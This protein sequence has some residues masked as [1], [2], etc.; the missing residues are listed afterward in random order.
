MIEIMI[1]GLIVL[2]LTTFWQVSSIWATLFGSPIVYS[3]K[4]AVSDSLHLA[5][6][7]KGDLVLD[8]GSGDGRSLIIAAKEFRAKGI[9]VD[10]SLFC[11]IRSKINVFLAGETKNIRIIRGDFKVAEKF[12]K[13]ADVVYLYLLNTTLAE[14]E[15]WLFGSIGNKT[16][17]VSLVFWFPKHKPIA[18]IKT[19]TLGREAK[20]RLYVR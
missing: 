8:L 20:A 3:R 1:L 14:I 16:K 10:R 4:Q 18:E 9:G 6:V 7:E 11:Y 13:T 12:L 17:I 5:G 19:F 15:D 2:I